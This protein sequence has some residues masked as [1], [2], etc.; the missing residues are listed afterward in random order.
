MLL[1]SGEILVVWNDNKHAAL[2]SSAM[3]IGEDWEGVCDVVPTW[4]DVTGSVGNTDA[5]DVSC[6]VSRSAFYFCNISRSS[7]TMRFYFPILQ[8]YWFS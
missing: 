8:K 2:H 5:R 7:C 4:C 1:E 6:D 3:L